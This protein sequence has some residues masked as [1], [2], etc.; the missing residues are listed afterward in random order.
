MKKMF[1]IPERLEQRLMLG[2]QAPADQNM[3]ESV[4]AQADILPLGSEFL[5]VV[6]SPLEPPVAAAAGPDLLGVVN[7]GHGR[8]FVYDC[9]G[10]GTGITI[11]GD[12]DETDGSKYNAYDP[13]NDLAIFGTSS[14]VIVIAR[15]VFL[16]MGKWELAD[17]TG[18]GIA[19]EGQLLTFADQR[20]GGGNVG[21][22]A[23][24][25]GMGTVSL[26]SGMTGMPG[27]DLAVDGFMTI[28]SGASIHAANG[29]INN[30]ILNSDKSLKGGINGREIG[31]LLSLGDVDA[32]IELTRSIRTLFVKKDLEGAINAGGGI[33]SLYCGGAAR[34]DIMLGGTMGSFFAAGPVSGDINADSIRSFYSVG[35]VS[36]HIR[37]TSG[38]A[39]FVT[40]GSL[41]PA[42]A[43]SSDGW[44]TNAIIRGGALGQINAGQMSTFL[45]QLGDFDGTMILDGNAER[46]F[47]LQGDLAG[48]ITSGGV[49]THV[50]VAQGV[51]RGNVDARRIEFFRA[52]N[53]DS[54]VDGRASIIADDGIRNLIVYGNMRGTDVGVGVRSL[55]AGKTVELWQ[56][57]V[58]RDIDHSNVL[59]GVWNEHGPTAS[60][61]NP[62]SDGGENGAPYVPDSIKGVGKLSYVRVGGRVGTAGA[63]ADQWAIASQQKVSWV[64]RAPEADYAVKGDVA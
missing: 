26:R 24:S 1:Q 14:G 48:R 20:V 4:Y 25:Q 49:L 47:V 50:S 62:F 39:T 53:T 8:V 34:S 38:I 37:G 11:N 40:L 21:F 13:A 30:I 15:A 9:D 45:V 44:I 42:S 63:D 64:T 60:A 17:S 32:E 35:D 55:P 28:P 2:G 5:A 43:L 61:S 6:E 22:I 19:V 27:S 46:I 57:Y 54:D 58:G 51:F 29:A 36:S 31:L 18:I 7:T 59:V 41:T 23:A 33:E 10:I 16:N 56:L 12:Y 3:A 52:M